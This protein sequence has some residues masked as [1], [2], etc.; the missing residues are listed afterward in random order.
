MTKLMGERMKII[1]C[2]QSLSGTALCGLDNGEEFLRET[3]DFAGERGFTRIEKIVN[4]FRGIIDQ[5]DKPEIIAM[6]DYSGSQYPGRMIP[7][8]ELGGCVKMMLHRAGYIF[9]VQAL[10]AGARKVVLIQSA[11]TMKKFMLGAGN[12]QK[13]SRYLLTV[14]DKTGIRFDDDNQADAYMHARM[15]EIVVK[16]VRGELLMSALPKYQQEALITDKAAGK[17]KL[18]KAKALKLPDAE[19]AKLVCF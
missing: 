9:G 10:N 17:V 5:H 7:L 1:G 19:R 3:F 14:A 12:V 2:D 6:E 4:R 8:V 15:A 11:M 18:S 16:V 13:D